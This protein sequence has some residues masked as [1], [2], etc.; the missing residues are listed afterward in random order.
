MR[1]SVQRLLVLFALINAA[2]LELAV[3][4]GA[5]PVTLYVTPATVM[6]GRTVTVSGSCEVN[7]SGY[8]ISPAFLH[9]ARHDFA[10]IGAVFFRTGSTGSFITHAVISRST[11]PGSYPITARCGGGNLGIEVHLTVTA[12]SGAPTTVLAGSSGLDARDPARP[13]AAGHAPAGAS[14]GDLSNR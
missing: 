8:V 4:A 13:L 3:A 10:G 2:L 9:D 12:P 11:R 6:A 7:S 5:V 1:M 14:T